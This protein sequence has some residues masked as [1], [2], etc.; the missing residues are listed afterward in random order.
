[1]WSP[2]CAER[3]V[4]AFD[5]RPHFGAFEIDPGLLKLGPGLLILGLRGDGV[6]IVGFFCSVV[7]ARSVN[8]NLRLAPVSTDCI[9]ETIEAMSDD[10]VKSV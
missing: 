2:S 6:C 9:G 10:A 3:L 8:A 1:M 7:T 5:R 4:P